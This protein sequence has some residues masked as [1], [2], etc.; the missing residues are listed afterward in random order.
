VSVIHKTIVRPRSA[1]VFALALAASLLQAN[2]AYG[3]DEENTP[4][5]PG[6]TATAV[7]QSSPDVQSESNAAEADGAGGNAADSATA[8]NATAGSDAAGSDAAEAKA[9]PAPILTEEQ[10]RHAIE[11]AERRRLSLMQ[12]DPA[13]PEE[14]KEKWGVEIIGVSSTSGGYML[15]FRFRVLDAQKS[16]SLFDH[17]IKPYVVAEKSHIKLPVPMAAKVGALRPTNRGKNIKADKIYYMV[18]ANPD[19]HVK[20]GEKV[21]VVIGDFRAEGLTVR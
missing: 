19:H 1:A 10:V 13:F 8:G 9:A 14:L 4:Q 3:I 15:D 18:F 17:R 20:K 21:S 6:E 12:P 5:V 11:E 16:L 7:E 2:R